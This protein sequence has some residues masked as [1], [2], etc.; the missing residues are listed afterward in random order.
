M[1]VEEVGSSQDRGMTPSWLNLLSGHQVLTSNFFVDLHLKTGIEVQRE[2]A[3][4]WA[5]TS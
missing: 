4:G 1:E 3:G 5:V 2:A